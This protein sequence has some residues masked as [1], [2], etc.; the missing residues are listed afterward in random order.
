MWRYASRSSRYVIT[1][2]RVSPF[3]KPD[4]R[5]H[6]VVQYRRSASYSREAA[7]YWIALSRGLTNVLDRGKKLGD[8]K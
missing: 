7:A 4:D 5:L 2:H 3:G 6:R 1:R 8:K